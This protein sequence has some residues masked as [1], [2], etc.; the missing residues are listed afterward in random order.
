MLCTLTKPKHGTLICTWHAIQPMHL[1]NQYAKQKQ[2]NLVKCYSSVLYRKATPSQNMYSTADTNNAWCRPHTRACI[3][4]CLLPLHGS[5]HYIATYKWTGENCC[6]LSDT[7]NMHCASGYRFTDH[8][9]CHATYPLS[10][11]INAYLTD[12]LYEKP[13]PNACTTPKPSRTTPP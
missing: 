10:H 9:H 13:N 1:G 6:T 4:T 8:H 11:S 3:A 12:K 7:Y 5:T 2:T